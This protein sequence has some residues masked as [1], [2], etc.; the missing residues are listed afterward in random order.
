MAAKIVQVYDS[1]MRVHPPI[2]FGQRIE[3]VDGIVRTRGRYNMIVFSQLKATDVD[4]VVAEQ[5]EFFTE[6]GEDVEWKLYGHDSPPNL[7]ASL[8]AHGFEPGELETLMVLE[9]ASDRIGAEVA[10]IVDVRT[11]STP[12]DVVTYV[13]VTT[14][15]FGKDTKSS[16]GDFELRLLREGADTIAV[17]GYVEGKPVAAGRLELPRSRSFAGMWAGGTNPSVRK[18]GIYRTLVAERARMARDRGYKYL[19]VDALET[20]RPILERLGF[21]AM[22]T[23]RAWNLRTHRL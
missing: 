18:R 20:S 22:T 6:L 19:T 13:D 15:I 14:G 4:R 11:V 7:S 2:E 16:I 21:S 9:L 12:R 23:V 1:E 8:A 10:P 3:R 17:V 5:V